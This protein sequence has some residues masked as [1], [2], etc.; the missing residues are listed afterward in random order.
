M[1]GVTCP[2]GVFLL[3]LAF[4]HSAVPCRHSLL[5][6]RTNSNDIEIRHSVTQTC[7]PSAWTLTTTSAPPREGETAGDAG[8]AAGGEVAGGK[9][10]GEAITRDGQ[11]YAPATYKSDR[12]RSCDWVIITCVCVCLQE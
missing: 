5:A 4:F 12:C 3:G 10:A 6:S 1:R 11:A 9:A 8:E 2:T 7:V